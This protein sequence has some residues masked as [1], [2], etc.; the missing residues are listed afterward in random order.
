M[1]F[2]VNDA[3]MHLL[4]RAYS[5]LD[6]VGASLK[7]TFFD[8]SSAFMDYLTDR[9]QY[10]RLQGCKSA[11]C[12]GASQGT[13]LSPFL[14]TLYTFDFQ[15]NTEGCHLQKFSDDSAIVGC[16][17]GEDDLEYRIAVD[18]FVHWCELNQLK[19]NIQKTKEL[20]V[21]LRRSRPPVTP[22]SIRGV[23][24]EIVQDYKYLGVHIDNKLDWSKNSLVTYKRGQS[25]LDFLRRL[26]SFRV[27][28]I[29]LRM[30][31][32]SVVASP[33]FYAVVCWGGSMKV[34]DMKRLNK[35]IRKAG[36]VVGEEL[37]NM[38]TVVER[39]TLSRLR[40]IMDNVYHPLY[41][42]VDELRSTF[43][44]TH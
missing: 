37:D 29:M 39:R 16:I 19:L 32:E 35:L 27:C 20:V 11:R 43:S 25:R 40:S 18:S 34:A 21:D 13:V 2:E 4:Y 9:P 24:V 42:V 31:Y 30:F 17:K 38:E 12:T 1:H 26:R 8:F 10:I 28:N 14:F 44:Q 36:S 41:N 7:I 5:H 3:L 6:K 15:Y 33:I 23:D 22:L